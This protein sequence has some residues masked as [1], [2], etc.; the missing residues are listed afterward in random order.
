MKHFTLLKTIMLACM[1]MCGMG[2]WAQVATATIADGGEYVIAAYTGGK[3]Y[4]LPQV[5]A[6]GTPAGVEV[7]LNA[8]GKV[9]TSTAANL[10]WKAKVSGTAYNLTYIDGNGTTQYLYKNGTSN[11]NYNLNKSTTGNTW[12]FTKNTEGTA[13]SVAANR[14]SNNTILKYVSNWKVDGTTASYTIIL[15]EIGDVPVE[16]YTVTFNA[17]TNGTCSTSSLTESVPGAGVTL[18][19]VTANPNYVFKGWST[20]ST[21]TSANAGVANDNYKPTSNI[22]LYAYYLP[23][24]TLTISQPVAGGTLTVSD[25]NGALVTGSTVEVGTNLTC[26]VTNIPEGKRFSRFY[27]RYDNNGEKYKVTNPATFENLPTEGIT[28]ATVSVTYQ[29]LAQYTI[30]YM[31]NGV[32]TNAQ[33]NVWE[34]TTLVFPVPSAIGEKVFCGWSEVEIDGT[35]NDAPSFVNTEGLKASANKTYYAVFANVTPGNTTIITDEITR[36]TTGISNG[37]ST[38]S[39]WSGK[40][41]TSNAVY[42]GNSAGSNDAIQ[43]RSANTNSGIVSTTTGGNVKK[44][45][46]TWQSNTTNGRTLDVYGSNSA[47][48]GATDLYDNKKCGTKLGSIVHGTSTELS[49]DGDYAYVG[50]RSND[51]AMYLT[52]VSI[53]WENGTPDT[54]SNYCTTVAAPATSTDITISSV[55]YATFFDAD[56][57]Y[58]MPNDCEGYVFTAARGLEKAYDAEAV[59][60]AG[61]PLVIYTIKPGTKTLN[62]TTST[63]ETYKDNDMNNLCGAATDMTASEMVAA[64]DGMGKFYALSLNAEGEAS[65]VGFYWVE[66]N[67]AA[68]DITAGKAYLALPAAGSAKCFVF[69]GETDGINNVEANVNDN[70]MFNLAGQRVNASAKGIVIM[71]GK[72]FI[73]K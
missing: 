33:E 64:N 47:Y 66:E 58:V 72:K 20:S 60:P 49:V 25:T 62:F 18:P 24:Y 22:I 69:N 67:G 30:N 53:D 59:V 28:A 7:S 38:Y 57:A 70:R 9:N 71:N 27:V 55:G 16:T 46:V 14:G 40:T 2:A 61:E 21:P 35:T 12:T 31:V 42:A 50:L 23:T 54:Y 26:E 63:E 3:Y 73:N 11:T 36:E 68:F 34:G 10:K 56:H 37:A 52:Q 43:I 15:L 44:I 13:Y 45:T 65:S 1:L 41:A 19:N 17:G 6:A 29:N 48:T 4:A 39:N 8:Q 32:N 5:T 51:G